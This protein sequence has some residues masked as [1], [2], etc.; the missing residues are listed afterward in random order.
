MK[1]FKEG[2]RFRLANSLQ[3]GTVLNDN[4]DG[5]YEV[6][7][8]DQ[9]FAQLYLSE[10]KKTINWSNIQNSIEQKIEQLMEMST[11]KMVFWFLIGCM[12]TYLIAIL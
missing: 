9:V 2:E 10:M 7:M 6:L 3:F 12:V 11:A 1:K 8:S 4:I 5:T